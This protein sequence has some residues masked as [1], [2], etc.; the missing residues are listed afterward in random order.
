M[1]LNS[2]IILTHS[3]FFFFFPP[4]SSHYLYVNFKHQLGKGTKKKKKVWSLTTP[5]LPPLPPPHMH[6]CGLLI[7]IKNLQQIEHI[8]FKM[9]FYWRKYL[10][11]FQICKLEVYGML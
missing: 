9:D 11:C 1:W 10:Y 4:R 8:T 2:R 5:H 6:M 3:F 7:A